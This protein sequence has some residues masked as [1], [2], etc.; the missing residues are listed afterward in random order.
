M[1]TALEPNPH[2]RLDAQITLPHLTWTLPGHYR[3]YLR[4]GSWQ[5]ALLCYLWTGILVMLGVAF[6]FGFIPSV[7]FQ[8]KPHALLACLSNWDGRWFETIV[9]DGYSFSDQVPPTAA[10]FPAYPCLAW[11]LVKSTGMPASTALVLISQLSFAAALVVFAAY[12]RIRFPSEPKHFL[13]FV[14]LAATLSPTTF[15]FRMA[16]SE[17]L[18]LF[19]LLLAFYLMERKTSLGIVAIVVGFATSVRI[20]GICLLL[21]FAMHIWSRSAGKRQFIQNMVLMMPLACWGA[22]V[23][24]IYCDWRSGTPWA[25][26]RAQA[27]WHFRVAP[28]WGYKLYSLATLE[29]LWSVFNPSSPS[30]WKTLSFDKNPLFSLIAANPIYFVLAVLL[31]VLGAWRRWLSGKETALAASLLFVSY[32]GRGYEMCMN[33]TGRFIAVVFPIYLV[34][35]QLLCRCPATL[36]TGYL[37]SSAIVL[38]LYCAL[39]AACHFLI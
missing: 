19:S 23:F 33:S 6:G 5:L 36:A 15:F 28:S 11:L 27:E 34:M 17:S 37:T 16:Y 31:I 25:F 14:L 13:I 8:P 2:G 18:F 9:H 21:P 1:Q 29:P 7:T 20:P 32:V 22:A 24:M 26:A 3:R 30:Y 12:I 4:L 38:T 35:A 10:F 39:F